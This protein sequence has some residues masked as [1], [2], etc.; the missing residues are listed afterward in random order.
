MSTAPATPPAAPRAPERPKEIIIYSHSTLFYWWPVWAAGFIMAIVTA[1]SHQVLAV[2]PSGTKAAVDQTL[3]TDEGE[4]KRDILY[5]PKDKHLAKD[6]KTDKPHDPHLHITRSKNVGPWFCT[7]LLL[8]IFITNVPLRGLWSVIVIGT[9]VFLAIIFAILDWWDPI[10]T[11]LSFL[12]IRINMGGYLF[13]SIV[14]LIL[15]LIIVFLFDKQIYT[16]ITPRQVRVRHAIGEGEDVYDATGMGATREKSDMFRHVILGFGSGDIV[17]KPK[18]D[19]PI[20]LHNVLGA[21]RRIREITTLL[22]EQIIER[23]G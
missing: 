17:L 16:V 19:P 8:T 21:W 13:I 11:Y 7:I 3:H 18:G 2:V 20:H 12:D 6:A 4:I 5:L 9:I 14:L 1:F 15:W 22:Q 10:L 23:P